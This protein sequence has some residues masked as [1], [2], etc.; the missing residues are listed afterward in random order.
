LS[1]FI[2]SLAVEWSVCAPFFSMV[3]RVT[4]MCF[5]RAV[6]KFTFSGT[7]YVSSYSIVLG[8]IDSHSTKKK[9]AMKP[10]IMVT[11]PSMIKIHLHHI[12]KMQ[13]NFQKSTHLQPRLYIPSPTLIKDSAY[14][15]CTLLAALLLEMTSYARLGQT[16]MPAALPYKIPILVLRFRIADTTSQ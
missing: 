9:G 6:R 13:Y 5:C 16:Q 14:A 12:S 15:N 2:I 7:G 10:A 8:D 4:A 1:I 3:T 11:T